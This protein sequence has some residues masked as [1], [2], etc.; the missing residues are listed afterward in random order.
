MSWALLFGLLVGLALAV[1]VL[2]FRR[3]A[4]VELEETLS[5]RREARE[6]GSHKARLAY[7]HVDLSRCLGCAACVQACP[8][9]GVLVMIH[10]QAAVA[11]GARC[12]GHGVCAT[13]CPTGAIVLTFAELDSRRDLPVIDER[14]EV[15]GSPGLFLAGEVTGYALIRTAIQHGT[16]LGAEV[17]RRRA[18]GARAEGGAF[19]LVIV[20]A[21]PAGLACALEAKARG[22]SFVVLEQDELGG[23]VAKYPRAKLVMTEPVELPLV[24]KLNRSTYSKEELIELWQRVA[25]E[26][27]L[28]IRTGV[29]FSGLAREGQGYRLETDQGALSARHVVLAL[30]RRGTPKRLGVPGEELPKVAY[31][32][33]D[34]QA[35]TGRHV[36]VVGGGDSAVEG[37]LALAGQ[38][39]NV[40][41]LSYRSAHF[42]RLKRR[43]EE[44]L[45]EAEASGAL[46]VLRR[47]QVRAI[48]HAQAELL[49]EDEHGPRT[50]W[51]PNDEVFVLI[52]GDPPFAL[53]ERCG[54]SF[55]PAGRPRTLPPLERGT[56][57]L[58]ALAI[59]LSLAL[60]AL[61]WLGRHSSYYLASPEQR[62]LQPQHEFLRPGG[63]IGLT[64]G[65]AATAMI[66]VNLAYLARR[67]LPAVRWG[68][69]KSWMLVHVLS[70]VLALLFALVHGAMS[71]QDALGERTL[72]VMA[73]L[74]ASGA[75]GRYVYAHVPRATN[76]RELELDELQAE[77]AALAGEWERANR[78]FGTRVRTEIQRLVSRQHGQKRL[79]TRIVALLWAPRALRRTLAG[80]RREG[81]ALGIPDVELERLLELARRAH[82]TSSLVAHYE[83]L[84]ALL[85]TWRFVHRWGAVF[86]VL[87]VAL[88]VLVAVR[89]GGF[90]G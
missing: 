56:G 85:G 46:R 88:H 18:Q 31:G 17:A 67:Y 30:G 35:H 26:H 81:R 5:E 24:G 23:T 9:E 42:T 76:G 75:V 41:T 7:P 1:S 51:I 83:D 8:E 66:L 13:E 74:V 57:L 87:I 59:A 63:P 15:P 6:R 80:L 45:A 64:L 72:A 32:L 44:R 38:P 58:R 14:F 2:V 16:A 11:H 40:V 77:L 49:V 61:G 84:R 54:V 89:Y 62:P 28:P 12:V 60:V 52:G 39:G 3:S 53:L 50:G 21:G 43:N 86:L 47:S 25:A 90:V 37:A 73:L 10:G 82:R 48:T 19:D 55:D 78:E 68:T 70:G 22:L 4:L 29:R 33:L 20:G 71:G 34:A 79:L 65:L 36:L 69:V 27:A